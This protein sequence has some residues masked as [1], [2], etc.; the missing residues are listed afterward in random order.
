MFRLANWGLDGALICDGFSGMS[1]SP[2]F[3]PQSLRIDGLLAFA[4]G[5]AGHGWALSRRV[6]PGAL[7]WMGC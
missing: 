2:H 3:P 5:K 6:L 1:A 4:G 7:V